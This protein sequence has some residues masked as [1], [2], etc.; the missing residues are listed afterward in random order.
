MASNQGPWA[1]KLL[2]SF[3][4]DH[5]DLRI[6]C[7]LMTI[8][9]VHAVLLAYA[10][11]LPKSSM[12]FQWRLLACLLDCLRSL[13]WCYS[14]FFHLILSICFLHSVSVKPLVL[15]AKPTHLKTSE[16]VNKKWPLNS[17]LLAFLDAIG[18]KQTAGHKNKWEW[19]LAT[20]GMTLMAL[21]W[22]MFHILT[23]QGTLA[24]STLNLLFSEMLIFWEKKF[25]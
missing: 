18:V 8:K 9:G 15:F 12:D 22:F 13:L 6:S 1:F 24:A 16:E 3:K 23:L 10:L 7:L 11:S 17:R 19:C 4:P 5:M 20:T 2:S 14:N 21:H 25:K